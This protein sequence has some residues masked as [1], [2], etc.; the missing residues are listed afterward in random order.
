MRLQKVK[1]IA[2]SLICLSSCKNKKEQ[3]ISYDHTNDLITETSPYLLQHA[4]NPV[5]WNPWS[6]EVFEN[7]KKDNK[8]VLISIGYSS[9]HWC[10]VMEEETFTDEETAKLM[11]ANFINVKVDR[12]ERPDVD[13]V[14]MTALQLMKGSGGWP[15]NVITLPNGK[16]IYGGT[17][18]TKEEWKNVLEKVNA[19][20]RKDAV[21]ANE[22]ADK[23][24]Q[25]IE[26]ISLMIPNST[27]GEIS[28]DSIISSVNVWKPSWD[29]TYGGDLAEQKFMLPTNLNFLLD[30]AI[31]Y[32]DQETK[33]HIK[34]TLDHIAHSGTY[35]QLGGGFFRYSTVRDWSIPHFEKML[36]DNAQ[37]ISLYA[38]AYRYFKDPKYKEIV[39]GTISFL[40]TEMKN[41]AGGFYAALDADTE[42]EEGNYYTWTKENIKKI[43]GSDFEI[44]SDY[45]GL[46]PESK[47]EDDKYILQK[48]SSDIAFGEK[49]N[50]SLEK[51]ELLKDKWKNNLLDNRKNRVRPATDDKI[52]T[53]WNSLLINGYIA[54]YKAFG[55]QRFLT[56]AIDIFKFIED[57]IFAEGV[58]IH[59][60]KKGG[61]KTPGFLEDYAGLIN[62]CINLYTVTLDEKYLAF[63]IKLNNITKDRFEDTDGTFFKYKENSDL[64]AKIIATQDGVMDS[65]NALM[66]ENLL[67]LGHIMYDKNLLDK[68]MKM[69]MAMHPFVQQNPESF[70]KWNML[71]MQGTSN[72][73]E[74]AVV[75]E[76]TEVFI[77]ALNKEYIPNVLIVGTTAL[78]DLPLFKDRFVDNETYIYVCQNNSCML[79]TNSVKMAIEKIMV[80]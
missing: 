15:L 48:T 73:Y 7:A 64:I 21:R 61:R 14:Y 63:A 6:N 53:S 66:A 35:D 20:Y 13:K 44:F 28:K 46:A 47:L 37:A 67:L 72:Y 26:E 38:K 50:I 24:A 58:L 56:A 76:N 1:L 29:L 9:C 70:A 62:A 33:T 68:S 12:E 2:L 59:S 5:D 45:Y 78:S 75:G 51:L 17:Y 4:H 27:E 57:K 49:H 23:I 8:L 79:P 60:Y 41:N 43:I 54:S 18:H 77:K 36:Y 11:N 74:V 30:Y 16:P 32:K 42:G 25:G 39:Y 19:F 34:N 52:I 22:Y 65:P 71:S 10:H 40:E 3:E 69:V 80:K 31:L 55:E